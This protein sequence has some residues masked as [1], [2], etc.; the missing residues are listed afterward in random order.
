MHAERGI[1]TGW[2]GTC[3][4]R[5]EER[6]TGEEDDDRDGRCPEPAPAHGLQALQPSRPEGTASSL[7]CCEKILTANDLV[8][9]PRR[10]EKT[11]FLG[12]ALEFRSAKPFC[13]AL[14]TYRF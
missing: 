4:K 8:F 11:G 6:E 10:P 13:R 2:Y 7:R 5:R 3:P 12:F 9:S 14:P 1:R